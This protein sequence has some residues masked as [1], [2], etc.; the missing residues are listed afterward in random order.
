MIH[1][2]AFLENIGNS[3]NGLFKNALRGATIGCLLAAYAYF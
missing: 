2:G 1:S 3:L